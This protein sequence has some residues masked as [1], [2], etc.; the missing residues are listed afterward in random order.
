MENLLY[1]LETPTMTKD[2]AHMRIEEANKV[3]SSKQDYH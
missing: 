1:Q 3:L 2:E